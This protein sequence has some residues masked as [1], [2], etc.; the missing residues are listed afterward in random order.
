MVI[1]VTGTMTTVT[2]M[3][4]DTIMMVVSGMIMDTGTMMLIG[5][6][7]K[8]TLT[9]ITCI[10]ITMTMIMVMTTMEGMITGMITIMDIK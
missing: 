5:M 9:T 10:C 8:I 1:M 3:K 4:M 6:I 7:T 2:G